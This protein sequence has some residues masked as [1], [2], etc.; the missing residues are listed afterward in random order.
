MKGVRFVLVLATC[1]AFTSVEGQQAPDPGQP[2]P[3]AVGHSS[4]TFLD[5]SRPCDLGA[6]PIPVEIF[7]PVDPSAVSPESPEAIYPLDPINA[8]WPL[9]C[10]SDWEPYGHDRAYEELLPS[11]DGPFPLILFSPGWGGPIWGH[12]F[13][14]GRAASH[15]FVVAVMYHY[16][17]AFFPG[18]QFDHISWACL[19]RPADVSFVLTELLARNTT[20]G[21][22]LQG[23]IDPE[24]VAASGWSLGGFAAMALAGGVDNLGYNT[25]SELLPW[26]WPNPP[27]TYVPIAPDPRIKSI[28]PLD[29]S[30]QMMQFFELARVTVPA[31]GI[32]EEWSTMAEWGEPWT[33]WQARQHA[34][35]QGHPSYRVDVAG[36]YHASFSNLCTSFTMLYETGVIDQETFEW[37]GW[38]CDSPLP[39][40]EADRVTTKYLIAFLKKHLCHEQG[41][42]QILTPGYV[43]QNEPG[44]EFFVT[45]RLNP[46]AIDDKW[47]GYFVYFMHQPGTAQ[48]RAEMNPAEAM[49]HPH[50]GLARE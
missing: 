33:S 44:L 28:V 7:Y 45:E 22:L 26:E 31:M 50:M 20:A 38:V 48:A 2:G 40:A 16:G 21:D 32:G 35:F 27:E 43:L 42:Q 17:D 49:R 18:E 39:P 30:N 37:W 5:P 15:G 3:Y 34:A 36:A 29:G 24:L 14:A 23:L 13:L 4:I 10:S 41:Y 9:T 19:N 46:H 11:A 1:V 47:P 6:R 8:Y 25:E 12:N